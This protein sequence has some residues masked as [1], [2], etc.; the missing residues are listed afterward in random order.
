M[1]I[2]DEVKK[3]IKVAAAIESQDLFAFVV[4]ISAAVLA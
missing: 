1:G 2:E 3:A 4:L